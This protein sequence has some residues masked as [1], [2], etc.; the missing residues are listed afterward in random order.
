MATTLTRTNSDSAS[1]NATLRGARTV[2]VSATSDKKFGDIHRVRLNTAY[3]NALESAGLIPF[4][5]PPLSDAS[6][7]QR[8]IDAVDG[9]LLTGGEDVDPDLYGQPRHER[10]S[11]VNRQRDE[12][13]ISLVHAA[14]ESRKPILAICRGPQL[15]NVALG[16]TLIQDIAACVPGALDHDSEGVHDIRNVRAH[17]VTLEP[18][19]RAA[20]AVGATRIKVN[21]LHHQ[22]ILDPAPG[23]RVTGRAP[24]RIIEAVESDTEAWWVLAVQWHPEEM[25][26]SPE[27]WDRGI[28]RAFAKR[29]EEG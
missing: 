3:V 5:I 29:L 13:E 4:I 18:G 14:R 8:V 19:S 22:S 1:A 16:G 10:L 15:L 12:T 24:D 17:E 7:A 6:A 27:P 28:F 25:T 20:E 11:T 2:A 9:L 23:L 21:T 26:E